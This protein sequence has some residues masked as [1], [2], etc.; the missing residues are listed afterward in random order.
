[1]L[2]QELAG[3]GNLRSLL[4]YDK[5]IGAWMDRKKKKYILRIWSERLELSGQ[6]C[7]ELAE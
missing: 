6:T 1:M 3:N 2:N 7:R 5:V 4:F